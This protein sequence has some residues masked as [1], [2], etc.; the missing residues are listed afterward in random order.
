MPESGATPSE[1]PRDEAGAG[2]ARSRPGAD[3]PGHGGDAV[4]VA[5]SWNERQR[6]PVAFVW[7]RR[8][9]AVACVLETWVI[10]T[11]WWKDEGR[12]S[13]VYWRVRAGDRVVDLCYDRIARAWTLARVLS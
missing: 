4:P 13:C 7:R 8:R 1:G 10:E 3:R 12:I 6:R 2:H 5:V 9:Y 11:G